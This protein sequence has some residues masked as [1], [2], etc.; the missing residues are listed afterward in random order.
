MIALN[1]MGTDFYSHA[2]EGRDRNGGLSDDKTKEYFYSHARDG[3]DGLP[4]ACRAQEAISTHT[5][6][7]GVTQ[8]LEQYQ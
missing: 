1:Q 8:M 7:R 2:R 4:R 6:A 3:R 5:P